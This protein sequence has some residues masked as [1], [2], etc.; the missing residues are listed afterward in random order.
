MIYL[1]KQ[2]KKLKVKELNVLAEKLAIIDTNKKQLWHDNY[3][4]DY[5]EP[6]PIIDIDD[7]KQA[8]TYCIFHFKGGMLESLGYDEC[9]CGCHCISCEL[10]PENEIGIRMQE[11]GETISEENVMND[12]IEEY[13]KKEIHG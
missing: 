13:G 2:I 11:L 12:F 4:G 9:P 3:S 1:L 7:I 5:P 10:I 8:L 6:S